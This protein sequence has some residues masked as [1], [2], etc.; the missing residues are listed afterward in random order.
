M[1]Q[2]MSKLWVQIP[3]QT[4]IAEAR[5]CDPE[6]AISSPFDPV[7]LPY[8]TIPNALHQRVNGPHLQNGQH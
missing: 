4:Q 6:W 3:Q 1:N 2:T 7:P 5:H 8:L